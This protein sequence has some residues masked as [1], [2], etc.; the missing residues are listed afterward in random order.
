[1]TLRFLLDHCVASSVRLSLTEAGFEVIRLGDVMPA[2]SPDANVI[3]K[4]Q[5]LDAILVSNN[6]D[7]SDLVT[8][9]PSQY[10]GI[11][12]LQIHNQPRILSVVV[13]RLIDYCR[14][15]PDRE[16]YQGKLLLIEAHRIRRRE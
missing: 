4:A 11:V 13:Q 14:E 12:A 8:Y 7:F 10:G 6:G 2:D 1:M 15:H 3:A 16:H 9:P 5:E